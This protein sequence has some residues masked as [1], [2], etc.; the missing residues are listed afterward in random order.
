MSVTKRDYFL[1]KINQTEMVKR[2]YIAHQNDGGVRPYNYIDE[3][4]HGLMLSWDKLKYVDS[5]ESLTVDPEI[6]HEQINND[7]FRDIWPQFQVG[8]GFRMAKKLDTV[9]DYLNF[10]IQREPEP[11]MN[12]EMFRNSNKIPHWQIRSTR[13]FDT[14]N[15]GV[16]GRSLSQK[17]KP[18]GDMDKVW[19]RVN[20]P[21]VAFDTNDEQYNGPRDDSTST[22]LMD[23]SW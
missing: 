17:I 13:H 9:D 4:I 12:S 7:F 23:T 19:S 18:H 1:S 6:E 22:H 5:Y 2:V 15:D 14:S 8:Q 11:V 21:T 3:Q 10:D 16:T 20:E